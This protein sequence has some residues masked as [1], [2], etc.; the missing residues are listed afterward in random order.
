MTANACSEPGSS[1]QILS[2]LYSSALYV[3]IVPHYDLDF[4]PKVEW[5]ITEPLTP[6]HVE[7]FAPYVPDPIDYLSALSQKF[8]VRELARVQVQDALEFSEDC[9]RPD[10]LLPCEQFLDLIARPSRRITMGHRL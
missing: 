5:L 9:S 8:G 6:I 2:E 1:T 7:E 10:Q 3:Q 4:L